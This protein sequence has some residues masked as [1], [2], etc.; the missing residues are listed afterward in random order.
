MTPNMPPKKQ[1]AWSSYYL[2]KKCPCPEATEDAHFYHKLKTDKT[3]MAFV[4]INSSYPPYPYGFIITSLWR[5]WRWKARCVVNSA[6]VSLNRFE[7]CSNLN[8]K[9]HCIL[10]CSLQTTSFSDIMASCVLQQKW[11]PNY[12]EHLCGK[13]M[14]IKLRSALWHHVEYFCFSRMCFSEK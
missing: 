7:V 3:N 14:R 5:W 13:L 9:L 6:K 8:L 2:D 10:A 11:L 4:M 12:I 1:C